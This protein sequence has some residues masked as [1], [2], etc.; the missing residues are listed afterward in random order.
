MKNSSWDLIEN[1]NKSPLDPIILNSFAMYL[2]FTAIMCL[3]SNTF[4]IATFWRYQELRT[5]LNILIGAIA[6]CNLLST[7]QFPLVITS[8]LNQRFLLF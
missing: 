1:G 3:L 6:L 8:N 2:A 5:P 4:L 7:F